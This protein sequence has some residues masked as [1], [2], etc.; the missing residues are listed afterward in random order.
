MRSPHVR[1]PLKRIGVQR[2][3]FG[4]NY[5]WRDTYVRIPGEFIRGFPGKGKP[6]SSQQ[7]VNL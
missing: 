1:I 4:G 5:Q 7:Q 3:P 2:S 6:T